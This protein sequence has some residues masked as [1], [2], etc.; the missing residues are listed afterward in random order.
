MAR[1]KLE[2]AGSENLNI[3]A[4]LETPTEAPRAFVLFAHCFTCSKDTLAAS[5]IAR[6]LVANG[7]GVLRFDFTGLGNSE[8]EFSNSNFSS[9]IADL[10][11]AA[12]YLRDNYM[13]P[14]ILIGHSLGGAAVLAGAGKI[15]ELKGVV[16]IGAP[17]D[18]EH[19][20]KQFSCDISAIEAQGKAT[21]ELG[22]RQFTIK[23]QF[24]D[25]LKTYQL[26]DEIAS[27]KKALL[28]FHAPLDATVS[29]KEAEKIYSHAKH[30]KSFVSLDG[31][32]HLLSRAE[33]AEYVAKVITAWASRYITVAE[34]NNNGAAK[35]Q[36]PTIKKG[37][38][39]IEEKNKNFTRE[40]F[41]DTHQW[42]ADE[43]TSFGGAD[44]GP[45]PYEHLLAAL[46]ACTSMTIRMYAKR[47]NIALESVSVELSHTREHASDC[48]A[49]EA[50]TQVI[51][52]LQ[53]EVKLVGDLSVEER[54]KLL[55]IA[56]K[57]PVH[58]TLHGDIDIKTVEV[59]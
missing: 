4:L 52:V 57:C 37:H 26:S 43:P 46:G 12:D 6:A 13:A 28:I 11:S 32:D 55:L 56:D 16:T 58:K 34:S 59:S 30:P 20:V 42:I 7:F 15:P 48:D 24:L 1:T 25:D 8:G 53:R 33:D 44:L 36:R 51:D 40:V 9:N 29:I 45:D 2:F 31:A 23:K 54:E 10:I 27:L 47:K 49:C 5:R 41:A 18:P 21:V 3:A 22:G 50:S 14:S 17:S 39:L 19:V 38:V 35:S